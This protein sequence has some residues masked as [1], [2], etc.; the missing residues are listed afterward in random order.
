MGLCYFIS[1]LM[2][3]TVSC[4]FWLPIDVVKERMQVQRELGLYHYKNGLDAVTTI[5]KTEGVVGL[6]RVNDKCIYILGLWSYFG[7]VWTL[8]CYVLSFL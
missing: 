7:I 4:L 5:I 1:G 8:Q 2:A 3:E 6:Y